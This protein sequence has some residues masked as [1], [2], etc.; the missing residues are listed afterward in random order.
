M[1]TLPVQ[2]GILVINTG[3]EVH[4]IPAQR[5]VSAVYFCRGFALIHHSFQD[6]ALRNY[7]PVS[8]HW[9]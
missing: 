2:T 4:F 8:C 6:T 9:Q 5:Y 3:P 7:L 1:T